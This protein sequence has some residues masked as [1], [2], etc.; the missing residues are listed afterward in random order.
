MA[1]QR[2][3]P[4]EIVRQLDAARLA[5]YDPEE[6]DRGEEDGFY[7]NQHFRDLRGVAWDQVAEAL[8]REAALFQRFSDAD[9]VDDEAELYEEE[10]GEAFLP[11][12]D[13]WGLDIGVIAATL[14]LSAMGCTTVSSCNAGGFGGQHVAAFPYIA[15]FLPNGRVGEVLT[16]AERA[17]VGVDAVDGGIARLFADN[18]FGLHAFAKAALDHYGFGVSPGP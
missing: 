10:R 2:S 12:D 3:Y 7:G 4:V 11:E 17:G 1:P 5:S 13:L 16:F 8:I 6:A 15:F 14:A 9:D 18:D